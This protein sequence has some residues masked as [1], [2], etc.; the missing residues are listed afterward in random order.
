MGLLRKNYN[1]MSDDQKNRFVAV[2]KKA[3][4]AG[5]VSN[6]AEIHAKYFSEGIHRTSH[7]LPWHRE[8]LYRF[9]REL[10]TFDSGV[11]IPYWD[12]TSDNSPSSPLWADAFLGQF[13]SAWKLGRAFGAAPNSHLPTL[14]QVQTNQVQRTTYDTFW[15]GPDKQGQDGLEVSIHNPPHQWVGGVMATDYSPLDP[16]FYLHHCWIDMLWAWWQTWRPYVPFVASPPWPERTW[17]LYDPL[18]AWPDR[19]PANVLDHRKLG[20]RYDTDPFLAAGDV[21]NPSDCQF[22]LDGRYMLLFKQGLLGHQTSDQKSL[23]WQSSDPTTGT[24][25]IMQSDGNLVIY[26]D[27]NPNQHRPIWAS[28]TVGHNNSYLLIQNDGHLVIYDS[29][30][31]PLTPKPW[32]VPPP[33]KGRPDGWG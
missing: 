33:A 8:M 5:V 22:S 18:L 25:C 12:S 23:L 31:K 29:N 13:D 28:N 4:A 9:E 27:S 11:T 14:Q 2:L 21:L 3:N 24:T 17:G 26:D 20:Y 1:F 19:T 6:Y 7:F 10:Q 16:A 32:I 15:Y 30:W